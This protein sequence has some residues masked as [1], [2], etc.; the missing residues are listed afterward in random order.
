MIETKDKK[1]CSACG[2]APVNHGF[3]FFSKLMDETVGKI[4]DVFFSFFLINK[5]RKL[6]DWVEKQLFNISHFL[7]IVKYD[8]DIEK[9]PNGRSK[10][11][12]EEARR[13]GIE[14]KQIK[15]FGKCID[16]Y[17][18]KINGEIYF[19][20]SIPVPPWLPQEGYNW[21]DD[22]MIFAEKL[23]KAGIPSPATKT[24]YS[25]TQAFSAFDK[26]SKPLIV[27]P[28]S[29]SRGR[30]TTTN[31]NTKD[32][33]RKAFNLAY[34][35]SPSMVVQEHLFGSV[36]RATVVGGKLVGFFRADPPQVTGDGI[37]NIKE[38][39]LE[40]NKNRHERVSDIVVTDE[41]LNFLKRQGYTL[42]SVI[43]LG[44][45]INLLAKTGRLYGSYTK[46]MLPEVHSKMHSIFEKVGEIA[47]L[48]VAGFDL[49]ILDPTQDPDTQR[50]GVIECN[51]LPFIDLHY[52]SLEGEPVNVAKNVW[53]LW[54][55]N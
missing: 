43:P 3:M 21:A 37:K 23:Q 15:V 45:T 54:N 35:I 25:V 19:F 4:M 17:K 33:M 28:K 27:K 9:S 52:F 16:Y 8:D 11:I 12:W 24:V 14:M 26:L 5:S 36:Y 55:I 1:I 40:K 53:D 18:A 30:H 46:E 39:I 44:L 32:E 42:D 49:I 48:P 38:L 34:E 50:W 6:T 51:S 29:G 47:S 7:G 22:K 2:T 41:L 31:I 10:L 20:Q 13:R